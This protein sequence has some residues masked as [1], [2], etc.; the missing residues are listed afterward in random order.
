MKKTILITGSTDGIG[1]E[2]AKDLLCKGHRVLLHGRD[3]RKL[4][5]VQSELLPYG[6]LESYLADLSDLKQVIK[7]GCE[8]N[9]NHEKIDVLINNAGILKAHKTITKDGLDVRFVV[10]A[11]S[12]YLLTKTVLPIMDNNGRII[13][14]SSAAQSPVNIEALRG[15]LELSDMDAYSQSKLA[16]NMWSYF[17][18]TNSKITTIA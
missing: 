12:P 13:N 17:M 3:E 6:E 14:V 11:I 16:I 1:Y 8:I 9:K 18:A 4:S 2:A 15:N 10:N 5:K 7:L